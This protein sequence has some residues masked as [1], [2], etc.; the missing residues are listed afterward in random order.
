VADYLVLVSS[1]RVQVAGEVDEL[2]A[3]HR[4][5]IGPADQAARY[6]GEWNVV[7]ARGGGSQAHLLVRS[8]GT[9]DTVPPGWETHQLSLEELT[10]AYL[11]EPSAGALPGPDRSYDIDRS[12]VRK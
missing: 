1:G 6:A 10:L 4:V 3:A 7:H 11:R 5:L 9:S 2:L 12:K 8:N